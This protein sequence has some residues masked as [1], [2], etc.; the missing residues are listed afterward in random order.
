MK[1]VLFSSTQEMLITVDD[2]GR[3]S[4][5]DLASWTRSQEW[6]VPW[7]RA[8]CCVLTHDGRYLATG[9]TD[10]EVQIYRIAPK[11]STK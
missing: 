11:R 7:V 6:Q 2:T 1:G 8:Y 10:G 5:W 9:N 3:V 4:C